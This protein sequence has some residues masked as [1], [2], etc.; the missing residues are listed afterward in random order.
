MSLDDDMRDPSPNG[1]SGTHC[2][3]CGAPLGEHIAPLSAAPSLAT[4]LLNAVNQAV[5][6]T[7][8]DGTIVYWNRYAEQL[9]GW[10]ASEA[11]G[12]HILEVTPSNL[13]RRQ[14][15]TVWS[16]LQRGETWSG[17]LL[18]RRRDGSEFTALVTDAPLLDA[19]GSLVGVVGVS[20]DLTEVK[21][22][23]EALCQAK[24]DAA[25][26]EGVRLTAREIS[27]LLN[28][29]LQ[30]PLIMLS[31]LQRRSDL[32][33]DARACVD[34]AVASLSE[35]AEHVQQLQQVVRVE[36]KA[37]PTGPALDLDRSTETLTG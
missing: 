26:L 4:R 28:N 29:D 22:V 36:T 34:R 6:A 16:W 31:L 12:R 21:Q 3:S 11:L 9:Y 13:S 8:L 5:I 35:A 24:Q 33:G 15:A 20:A 23:A 37:T 17:E 30:L 27:H 1:S 18:L 32:P 25:R 19:N 7:D 14:A 2:A 10:E